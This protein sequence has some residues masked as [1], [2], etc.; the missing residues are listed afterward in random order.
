MLLSGAGGRETSGCPF[1]LGREHEESSV[2]EPV[3]SP[4]LSSGLGNVTVPLSSEEGRTE[5]SGYCQAFYCQLRRRARTHT[6]TH[7]HTHTPLR[8]FSVPHT[9]THRRTHTR[10]PLQDFS[11]PHFSGAGVL[12]SIPDSLNY[13]YFSTESAEAAPITMFYFDSGHLN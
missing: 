12:Q 10:T 13:F 7:A 5:S 8:D 2:S 6:R 11:V 4:L 3:F 9:R 1:G